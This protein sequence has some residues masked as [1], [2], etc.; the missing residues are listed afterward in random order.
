M[1][2]PLFA[3]F[4]WDWYLGRISDQLTS[5]AGGDGV[6]S[7]ILGQRFLGVALR[8]ELVMYVVAS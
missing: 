5:M 8:L 4:I 2:I 3:I 6:G 7:H 1:Q